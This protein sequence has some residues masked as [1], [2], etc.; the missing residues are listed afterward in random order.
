MVKV[1]GRR[2]PSPLPGQP[3]YEILPLPGVLD[4]VADLPDASAVTVTSSPRRGIEATVE[5]TE[6]L[7][8]RGMRPVP[9]LAARQ[10][11]DDAHVADIVERLV[12][13]GVRDVF[14]IGGDSPEPAGRFADGLSLLRAIEA[15]GSPFEHV[16]VP[17]YP[18]G[19]PLIDDDTL[20]AVLADKQDLATYTVTQLCFD[21]DTV[22]RYAAELRRRGITLPIVAGVPGVVNTAKLLRVSLRIGI[23]DSLS[24]VRK[25]RATAGRLLG[26]R[27]YRPDALI[28]RLS[29]HVQAGRCD[30]HG[31][32]VYTFNHVGPTVRRLARLHPPEM[33][34][35]GWP[36]PR[37]SRSPAAPYS[38]R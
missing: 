11:R 20:W 22:C 38:N 3:R 21:A 31:L 25:N 2:D 4:V 19:H 28:R 6:R 23:G 36:S 35:T 12:A 16:G 10:F 14:V 24:F 33:E 37:T 26:P 5:L 34:V 17:S 8:E 32:H 18:E 15:L 29:E 9:H 27:G 13:A 1:R 7:A 30:I